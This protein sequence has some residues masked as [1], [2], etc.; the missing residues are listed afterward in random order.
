MAR[1]QREQQQGVSDLHRSHIGNS[2]GSDEPLSSRSLG[3][4]T[5]HSRKIVA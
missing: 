4:D 5:P 2:T 3:T 1:E